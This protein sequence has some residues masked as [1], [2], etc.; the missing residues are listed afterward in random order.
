MKIGFL[1]QSNWDDGQAVIGDHGMRTALS[2]GFQQHH[3]L[4]IVGSV[5]V[6]S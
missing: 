4:L 2:I 5:A 6:G 3:A 1:M